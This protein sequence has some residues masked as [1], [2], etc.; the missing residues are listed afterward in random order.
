MTNLLAKAKNVE[1]TA[2]PINK[3]EESLQLTLESCAKTHHSAKIYVQVSEKH[4]REDEAFNDIKEMIKKAIYV[5]WWEKCERNDCQ[6]MSI[7]NFVS[8][9]T[10]PPELAKTLKTNLELLKIF[11]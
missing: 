5:R 10:C 9:S 2:I 11:A 8:L 1:I 3:V 7:I 6:Q 4:L